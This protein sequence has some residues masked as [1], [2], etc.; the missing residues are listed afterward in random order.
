MLSKIALKTFVEKL[1]TNKTLCPRIVRDKLSEDFS[2]PICLAKMNIVAGDS[3][4]WFKRDRFFVNPPELHLFQR[5]KNYKTDWY[6]KR[7]YYWSDDGLNSCSNYTVSFHYV[8]P[9]FMYR[10]HYFTYHMKPYGIN[11]RYP[12]LTKQFNFANVMRTLEMERLNTSY[13]GY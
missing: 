11:F 6:W 5:E 4:D 7:K 12:P 3:R 9:N 1:L 10:L 2:L 8:K 13:R